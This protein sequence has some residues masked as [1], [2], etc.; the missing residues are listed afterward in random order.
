MKMKP[1]N[2]NL[3]E[4]VEKVINLMEANAEK[5]QITLTNNVDSGIMVFADVNMTETVIRNLVS[6]GIKYTRNGENIRLEASVTERIVEVS[7]ID[8]GV[9]IPPNKVNFLF[10]IDRKFQLPGTNDET[11]TGLA[12]IVCKEFMEKN[13]VEI[14]VEN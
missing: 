10:C 2:L 4:I 8:N 5:K 9:G 12:L 6:N 14:W 13:K 3:N 11:G 7:V 1:E